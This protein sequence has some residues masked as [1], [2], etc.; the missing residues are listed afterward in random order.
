MKTNSRTVNFL[1]VPLDVDKKPMKHRKWIITYT[2]PSI[3]HPK[4]SNTYLNSSATGYQTTYL[5]YT[6]STT[7]NTI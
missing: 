4:I 2:H 3:T 1:D 7:K 6:F 5:R